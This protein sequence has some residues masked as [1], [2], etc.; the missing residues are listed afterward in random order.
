MANATGE[1][2]VNFQSPARRTR[3]R[4]SSRPS[5][6]TPQ[7]ADIMTRVVVTATEDT[8]LPELIDDMVR[9]G[10]SGV[11][12]VDTESRLIG[13]VTEADVMTKPA[14]GGTQRRSL[15]VLSDLLRGRE[16][17]WE[18]KATGLTAG[19]I[20]TTEV[21]TA[22]PHEAV[23]AAARRMVRCGIKRLPVVDADRLVGIVSRAD[24]LRRMHRTDAE[25]QA[26]IEAVLADPARVPETT[27]V[28][29][30][31]ADGVVTLRGSVRFPMDL[32]VLS[33]VV[34]RFPGVVDAIVEV[35]AREPDPAPQPTPNRGYD[36]LRYMR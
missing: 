33:A 23:Q 4:S 7:V 26:E 22:R 2:A 16:R 35:T 12:V 8:P 30:S 24:V 25:L 27:N 17:R 1:R 20:M 31:V 18:S 5:P 36:Y 21:E 29:V 11:P 32:P 10:I 15:A 34:W 28:D 3:R 14:Y 13:I 9:Y 19:Q 6:R